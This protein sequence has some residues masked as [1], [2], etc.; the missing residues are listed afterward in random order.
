[1]N[2]SLYILAG[3]GMII[4]SLMVVF[5]LAILVHFH[6]LGALFLVAGGLA[7]AYVVGKA[8]A[9]DRASIKNNY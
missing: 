6:D 9:D 7:A 4:A 2:W 5:G 8:V 1:M 3:V